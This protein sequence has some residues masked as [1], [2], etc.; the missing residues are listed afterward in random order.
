MLT[1]PAASLVYIQGPIHIILI[2]QDRSTTNESAYIKIG[3]LNVPVFRPRPGQNPPIIPADWTSEWATHYTRDNITQI[4]SNL[5]M[6]WN[7]LTS[8]TAAQDAA[9]TALSIAAELSAVTGPGVY[10][11]PKRTGVE[12]DYNRPLAGAF[13]VEHG[14][15][16]DVEPIPG[17]DY[18]A[19]VVNIS[20]PGSDTMI[21]KI[22]SGLNVATLSP[23][24]IPPSGLVQTTLSTTVPVAYALSPPPTQDGHQTYHVQSASTIKRLSIY[25]GLINRTST[26]YY[27]AAAEALPGWIHMLSHALSASTTLLLQD[28][29]MPV[30]D[31][32]GFNTTW[33]DNNRFDE[34]ERIKKIATHNL[35]SHFESETEFESWP[36]YRDAWISTAYGGIDPFSNALWWQQ[37]P[38]PS[39]LIIQW[40]EKLGMGSCP[41]LQPGQNP[42]IMVNEV[43]KFAARVTEQ[44]KPSWEWIVMSIDT[45]RKHPIVVDV[46]YRPDHSNAV[47]GSWIEQI[48]A[49]SLVSSSSRGSDAR[50]FETLS[51]TESLKVTYTGFIN[52]RQLYVVD[53]NYTEGNWTACKPRTSKLLWP[54]PPKF[55][56]AQ[57]TSKNSAAKKAATDTGKE[58]TDK[59]ATEKKEQAKVTP[60]PT[61]PS[62]PAAGPKT[63]PATPIT[64]TPTSAPARTTSTQATVTS[65]TPVTTTTATVSTAPTPPTLA[66]SVV[67]SGST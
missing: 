6:A 47:C 16:P 55:R 52:P 20:K 42:M 43:K 51:H 2:I 1:N 46:S 34:I 66:P 56:D 5:Q 36:M 41:D 53:S 45:K 64:T 10:L 12:Y 27:F 23:A 39:H 30:R 49:Q 8:K 62:D 3:T 13:N 29:D 21:E 19:T 67:G 4:V 60:T 32:A 57:A 44:V 58:V 24:H 50:Y 22:I 14:Q 61:T 54:D 9:G 11:Y 63:T 7:H 25:L 31:W 33:S 37:S 26:P 65:S 48:Q 38:T 35:I 59:T 17:T 18:L 28:I 15:S 40:R